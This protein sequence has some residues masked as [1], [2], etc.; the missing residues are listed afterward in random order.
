MP[1]AVRMGSGQ[2][3]TGIIEQPV[4]QR[5]VRIMAIGALHVAATQVQVGP[6]LEQVRI[7]R[8]VNLVYG[9]LIGIGNR[10]VRQP[11]GEI[12]LDVG[13]FEGGATLPVQHAAIGRVAG[14]AGF[15]ERSVTARL[16]TQKT[17]RPFAQQVARTLYRVGIMAV[18][19]ARPPDGQVRRKLA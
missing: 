17:V 1:A 4:L 2:R 11:R 9:L 14:V 19:A 5:P 18:Q 8:I 7:P 15:L 12:G 16:G 6:E 13:H 10:H 3:A